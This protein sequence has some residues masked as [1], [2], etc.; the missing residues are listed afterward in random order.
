MIIVPEYVFQNEDIRFE[1]PSLKMPREDA[2]LMHTALIDTR[3]L[4]VLYEQEYICHA[5]RYLGFTTNV[6]SLALEQKHGCGAMD[7]CVSIHK[8]RLENP[9]GER[10]RIANIIRNAWC[11][12]IRDHLSTILS[13]G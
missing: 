3:W 10:A 4:S 12:H 7:G 6:I 13:Q 8:A 2:V 5:M 9:L 11:E 1:C